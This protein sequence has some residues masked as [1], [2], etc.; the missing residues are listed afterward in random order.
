MLI[1]VFLGCT[2]R[3]TD[4]EIHQPDSNNTITFSAGEDRQPLVLS[5]AGDIMAHD[6]N[7]NRPPYNNIYRYV[8]SF[9]RTDDLSFANLEFPVNAAKEMSNYPLF[10]THPEYV[11]S[12]IDAGFDVFSLANNHISD[13][14][15][16]GIRATYEHM[17]QFADKNDIYFSGIRTEPEFP[18]M[19]TTFYRKEWRIG[20]LSITTFLNN[21]HGHELVHVVDY[22]VDSSRQ[23]FLSFLAEITPGYDLFIVSVHGGKEYNPIATGGKLAFFKEMMLRGVHIVWA[24]HPHVLQPWF[25]FDQGAGKRLVLPSCGNFIS[26]QTWH[27]DPL[28]PDPVRV[29]TGESALFRVAVGQTNRK[30]GVLCV[31]PYPIV[32][33]KHPEHGM[34]VRFLD[35]IIADNTISQEWK[36]FYVSRIPVVNAIT[37]S[38][39]TPNFMR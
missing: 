29:N 6:V 8:R 1:L 35:E 27:M 21:Y 10:N 36:K 32:N 17:Q 28:Q 38:N 2:P 19:P 24:H 33:Y 16:G 13:Q 23:Q 26:G 30:T 22:Q 7:Y 20:F 3:T 31:E 14:G 39:H 5:F 34:T 18:F 9:L 12:A 37:A 15:T 4:N 25:L 11:Q